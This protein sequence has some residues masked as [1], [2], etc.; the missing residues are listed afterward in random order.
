MDDP[1]F[2]V[3]GYSGCSELPKLDVAGSNPVARSSVDVRIGES[4]TDYQSDPTHISTSQLKDF[5]ESPPFFHRRHVLRVES[6]PPSEAMARGTLVHLCLELGWEAAGERIKVIPAE[7]LTGTGSLSTKADTKK[8]VADQ[9]NSILVTPQDAEFLGEV[10]SQC[11][12]NKG[13][14]KLLSSIAHKEVSIRWQR[15]DG[16][17]LRCRPDAI[18]SEGRVVDY[19]TTK[20]RNPDKDFWR[21]CQEYKYNLQSAFYQEGAAAAGFSGEPLIFVLISTVS[22]YTVVARTLPQRFI[23]LGKSQMDRALADLSARMAFGDWTPDGYGSVEELYVPEFCFK[24]T[25]GGQA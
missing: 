22:P 21:A 6:S 3:A 18:T 25:K 1:S 14:A 23:D 2:P 8:W 16:I 7:H 4:N 15:P 13:V 11:S 5:V 24:D 20:Y 17:K 9:G 10:Q 12:L 19:K